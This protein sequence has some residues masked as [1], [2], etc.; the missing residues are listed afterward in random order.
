MSSIAVLRSAACASRPTELSTHG[1]L[2]HR[3]DYVMQASDGHAARTTGSRIMGSWRAVLAARMGR[4]WACARH[5]CAA[6]PGRAVGRRRSSRCHGLG[7]DSVATIARL[8]HDADHAPVTGA[9]GPR[10]AELCPEG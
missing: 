1:V 2:S 3:A 7:L 5:R 6:S 4:C 8:G 10:H 9:V